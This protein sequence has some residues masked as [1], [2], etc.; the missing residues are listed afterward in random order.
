MISRKVTGIGCFAKPETL[1][2]VL[3][4]IPRCFKAGYKRLD[5]FLMVLETDLKLVRP[6]VGSG[7][8]SSSA[9]QPLQLEGPALG[10]FSLSGRPDNS[11]LLFL[12]LISLWQPIHIR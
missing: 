2:R 3:K 7:V 6:S 1:S 4:K 9:W 11:R 8:Y 5:S 10:N 12:A